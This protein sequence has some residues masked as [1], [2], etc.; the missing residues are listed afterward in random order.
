[1]PKIKQTTDKT[2]CPL[3]GTEI[4][5][6]D[7]TEIAL[8]LL[9]AVEIAKEGRRADVLRVGAIKAAIPSR[10]KGE[11]TDVHVTVYPDNRAPLLKLVKAQ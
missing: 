2:C 4:S 3:E 8:C 10:F 1:M 6:S 7:A 11:N 9:D 5:I